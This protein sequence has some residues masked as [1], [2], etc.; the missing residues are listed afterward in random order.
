MD[1][2]DA[3]KE[4]V[5]ILLEFHSDVG[6]YWNAQ[7]DEP[8]PDTIGSK[9]LASYKRIESVNLAYGQGN[10]L[11]SVA[12]D[13]LVAFTRLVTEPV[14]TVAPWTCIRAVLESSAKSLWLLDPEIN[15]QSRVGRS[16][17]FRYD[18]LMQQRKFANISNDSQAIQNITSRMDEIDSLSGQLGFDPVVDKHG[19]R[20]GIGEK[21]P[22]TTNLIQ[23]VLGM[24]KNYRI[25]S[26]MAHAQPSVLQEL[27]FRKNKI[28]NRISLIPNLTPFSVGFLCISAFKAFAPATR[29]RSK[30]YYRDIQKL[31]SL[32]GDA[33]KS[34]DELSN[35]LLE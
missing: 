6:D 14:Q 5:Q 25:L 8:L 24:G 3:A 11:I 17:A 21:L 9:E 19:R 33:R 15:I 13:H 23:A 32:I 26:G 29:I 28:G 16:L 34:I 30:L 2:L 35:I 22:Y 10:L 27:G 12:G 18:G 4:M 7:G 1:P 31:E 20:I